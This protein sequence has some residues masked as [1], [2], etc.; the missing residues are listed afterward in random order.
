[1]MMRRKIKGAVKKVNPDSLFTLFCVLT[2]ILIC[3]IAGNFFPT[4]HA[5]IGYFKVT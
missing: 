2:C 1:M 4:V 3:Y 5:L